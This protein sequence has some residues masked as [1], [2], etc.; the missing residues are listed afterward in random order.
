MIDDLPDHDDAS[1]R[2]QTMIMLTGLYLFMLLMTLMSYG[3]PIPLFGYILEG[4]SARIFIMID[5]LLCLYLFLGLWQR[6]HLTWILLLVYNGYEVLNILAN[7]FLVSHNELERIL[8][9]TIDP[10]G[11]LLS[12]LFTIGIV[13]WISRIIWKQREQFTNNSRYLF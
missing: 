4:K 8:E 10:R 3:Q 5:S 6:Q 13:L 2:S 1:P 7:L 11:M 9:R 12:N